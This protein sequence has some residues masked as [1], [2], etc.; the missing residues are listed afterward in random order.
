MK[1][2]ALALTLLAAPV[3]ASAYT[4]PPASHYVGIG[5]LQ[6]RLEQKE[7]ATFAGL[8]V[9]PNQRD[10]IV[11]FTR[12]AAATL[13]KYTTDSKFKPLDRPGPTQAD[14]YAA[15]ARL[16]PALQKL[17]AQPVSAASY[18]MTGRV[19]FEVVGDMAPV[20]AAQARGE[21]DIPPYV[22]IIEPPPLAYPEPPPPPA[23]YAPVKA[24]PRFKYRQGGP[25][26]S[27][28]M[29]GE[30]ELKDGCLRMK[31]PEGP[32]L[33]IVWPLEAALDLSHGDVRILHRFTGK[34]IRPGEKIV[35]GGNS[36]PLRDAADVT[37]EDPRCPGPYFLLTGFRT[38]AD[39][40]AEAARNRR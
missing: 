17:G 19:A 35:L 30:V 21:L 11:A 23:G 8:W 28:L 9:A 14:L 31:R 15:Q 20:R 22:D 33:V 32:D 40:E 3:A 29:A 25:E 36:H 38:Y 18:I 26:L 24:F 16:L 1:A 39:F 7:A 6:Q 4:P 5:A 2:A 12:D 27:I 13:R 10:V 37:G 34:S